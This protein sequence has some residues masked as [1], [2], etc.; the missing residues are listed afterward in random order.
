MPGQKSTFMKE[1]CIIFKKF[2]LLLFVTVP[3]CT[4]YGQTN[5][6]YPEEKEAVIKE[7]EE[8]LFS[9]IPAEKNPVKWTLRERMK[10]YHVNGVSIAVIKDFKIDWVRGYGWADSAGQRPVTPAT[11]FQA[12]S[13]SKSLNAVGV[14]KLVQ[15][16]KLGLYSDINKYLK[17]WKFPY[18]SLSDG[19]EITVANLLSHTAGLTVHGFPGYEKDSVLPGLVQILNGEKPANTGAVRSVTAPSLGYH[20]SGGG[21]T[22]SQLVA[23]DVSGQPYDLFMQKNVLKPLG[24]TAS[25]FTQPPPADK[26]NLLATGYNR[27]GKEIKGKY[28]IYPAAAAAGLWTTPS[29]LA[30]YIIET[31]LSLEGKSRKVLS[32]EMT[33]LR[34]TPY[35]NPSAALGVFIIN[36]NG[37]K[38]FQHQGAN[39]GF[40]SM[41]IGGFEDGTGAVV[42]INSSDASLLD[43]II[44]SI[45]RVYQ[46]KNFPVAASKKEGI[47]L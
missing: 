6:Q 12:A 7:V 41:Y 32:P 2:V 34:L 46:W 17:S 21:T 25:F 26:Q 28:H 33:V 13:I 36:K 43:E 10:H 37:T 1:R 44:N 4:A 9:G 11:L 47:D 16:G 38:Y 40:A 19:K 30:R 31:Q 29:D 24:M 22:I 18:D 15:E 8:N 5:P 42:I 20:Y 35:K 3:A 23:E 27:N 39:A 45:A 14:L